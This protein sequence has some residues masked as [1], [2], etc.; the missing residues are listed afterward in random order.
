MILGMFL[1][2]FVK[3]YDEIQ[4]LGDLAVILKTKLWLVKIRCEFSMK[5]SINSNVSVAANLSFF[6]HIS[7][8]KVYFNVKNQLAVFSFVKKSFFDI[9]LV[10]WKSKVKLKLL[11]QKVCKFFNHQ[12]CWS[13]EQNI[14]IKTTLNTLYLTARTLYSNS[15]SFLHFVN[16]FGVMSGH[17]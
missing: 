3:L 10:K 8:H 14:A 1:G 6:V 2:N 16:W 5:I 4:F 12:I 15:I 13:R 17:I 9:A 11:V 7:A